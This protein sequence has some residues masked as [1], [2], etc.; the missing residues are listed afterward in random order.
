MELRTWLS[1][2]GTL[3]AAVNSEQDLK[4]M[5]NLVAR[6]AQ[7]LL[8]LSFCAVM[9]PDPDQEYLMIEGSSGIPDQ[10]IAR[11]NTERPIRIEADPVEEAPASRAFRTGR[12]H[13]VSDLATA[14]TTVYGE[15][16]LRGG[17]QSILSVPLVAG[18]G[19]I[20]TLN[21]YRTDPHVF[22]TQ[23]I[24]Q[25]EL[26]AEH[27]TI[28]LTSA[29]VLDDVRDKHRLIVRSEEIHDRLL[30]VAVR[31]GGVA[32][33]ASALN[34]LL[35]CDVVIRDVYHATLAQ[36]PAE[37][38]LDV[39]AL[40]ALAVP[41]G[42]AGAWGESGLVRTV[43][44]HVVS[45]VVLDGKS[46]A[47]VWLLDRAESMDSLAV[48]A[49]EHASVV[50]S[51][52]L[53]RQ[54]TAAEVEQS[55]RGELLGDLLAGAD[56]ASPAVRDRAGLMN[57]NL[58]RTHQ[59]LIAA[60]VGS[61]RAGGGGSVLI[62]DVDVA[63]RAAIEAVRTTSHLRP[64][65]LIAAVRGFVVALWP[66]GGEPEVGEQALRRA[67]ASTSPA[68]ASAA[69][70]APIEVN[71]IPAAFRIARG[72][73]RF[74]VANGE[75]R[76]LVGLDQLGVAGLML[77]FADTDE[78]RRYAERTLGVVRQYDADHGAE[79]VKTLRVYLYC[80]LDRRI[81]SERLVLHPNTV[82]QRLRRIEVLS[83]L[84][85]RSPRSVLEARTALMLTDIADAVGDPDSA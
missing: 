60:A 55:L 64:R 71:G 77:Q 79:L 49:M 84:D 58:A 73:L 51:L 78:L 11:I 41:T 19:V 40:D 20:G 75:R 44:T 53:L 67:F 68:S 62:E 18:S 82:S 24:E 29:R 1:A 66:D 54:R 16:A 38:S 23:E 4:S 48:R 46:V 43:G 12:A 69:A 31:S 22:S 8:E 57:H 42:A 83:G 74:A 14:P 27:A 81:T 10:Y 21:S 34:D 80:D 52:E 30:S 7:D 63:Q 45:D 70:C 13:M 25:L 3:S 5:L 61:E 65:P 36:E 56:P 50:L 47:T 39:D 9:L 6:T 72:A 2:I 85:L 37:Q 76:S 32:G 59:L 26:L 17:Y 35:A 15:A 33:I 28:A